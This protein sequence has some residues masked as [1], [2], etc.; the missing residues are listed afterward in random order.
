MGRFKKWS[1]S[2]QSFEEL[3][4]LFEDMVKMI[5]K[6]EVELADLHRSVLVQE[7]R[8]QKELVMLYH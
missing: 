6:E 1:P 7:E 8:S 3:S 5:M 2:P 4:Q